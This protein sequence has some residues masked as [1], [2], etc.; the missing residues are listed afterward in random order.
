MIYDDY[1]LYKELL[2]MLKLCTQWWDCPVCGN[3]IA[4]GNHSNGCLFEKHL[5]LIEIDI[6]CSDM[7]KEL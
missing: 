5:A 2:K 3:D 6:E 1:E 4:D 7:E